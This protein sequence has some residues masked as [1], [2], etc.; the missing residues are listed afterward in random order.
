MT[1]C[2]QGDVVLVP[3]P[4]T[5][6]LRSGATPALSEAEGKNLAP[7]KQ[8]TCWAR[9]ETLRFAQGDI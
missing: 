5:V 2:R 1:R 7:G 4:F 8:E 9:N 6:I 3:F